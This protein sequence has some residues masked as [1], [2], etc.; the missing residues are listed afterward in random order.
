MSFFFLNELPA[1]QER[2]PTDGTFSDTK[3]HGTPRNAREGSGQAGPPAAGRP[4]LWLQG[5]K[6]GEER[7]RAEGEPEQIE[8]RTTTGETE[9]VP[10]TLPL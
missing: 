1:Q 6:P 10:R 8:L 2:K 4:A 3:Q 5:R 9:M 7:G